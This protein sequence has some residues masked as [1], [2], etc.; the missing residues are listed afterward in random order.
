MDSSC[1]NDKQQQNGNVVFIID[2]HQEDKRHLFKNHNVNWHLS[3]DGAEDSSVHQHQAGHNA[4]SIQRLPTNYYYQGKSQSFRSLSNVKCLKD[5]PKPDNPYNKFYKMK[6][7]CRG[8]L[9]KYYQ[10]KSQSFRSL[11]NVRCLE[12]LPKPENPYNNYYKM[13]NLQ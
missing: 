6:Y 4:Y 1:E 12:D 9:S 7:Y 10:G 11:S 2:D 13:R 8:G 5:L 3:S